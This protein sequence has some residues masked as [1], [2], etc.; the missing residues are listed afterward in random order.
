MSVLRK[1]ATPSRRLNFFFKMMRECLYD[2]PYPRSILYENKNFTS[3]FCGDD[4][5]FIGSQAMDVFDPERPGILLR[6]VLMKFS[7][8]DGKVR[9]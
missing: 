5:Y 7:C 9:F 1:L 6:S 4:V 2:G 3:C 8:S